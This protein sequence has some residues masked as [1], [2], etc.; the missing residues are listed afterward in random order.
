MSAASDMD[1]M[2]EYADRDSETAFA[3]LVH[4]H[5]NLVYSVALRSTGNSHDAQD[6]T[7]AVFVI[8]AKKATSLRQRTYLTGWLYE[9]TRFTSRQLLRTRSRQQAR[10][11]EAYMQST[12][13]DSET[14]SLWRQLAPL[15]DDAMSRLSEKDRALVA[16]RFFEN[17]SVAE[18]AAVLGIQEWAARKRVERAMQKLRGYFYKHGVAS[19]TATLAVAISVNSVQAAPT[20]LA[21]TAAAAAIAKGAAASTSTLTLAKGALNV[22]A[23]TKAKTAIVAGVG[24]LLAI[25]IGTTATV[26]VARHQ[27]S[28]QTQTSFPRS[29]WANAGYADPASALETIFWAQTQGDGKTYLASMTPELQQRL[30][31]QF[32]GDLAKQGLSLEDFLAQKSKDHIRPV[33]GFYIWGQQNVSGQLLLRVWIP[34]ARKNATFK[35]RKTE[36]E[37]KLDEEFLPDY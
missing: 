9:T 23:W 11:Q 24:I 37:W 14:D 35:M 7:Q 15:L 25:G 26:S 22:M 3:E 2:R 4:R 21:Q 32:A 33:T 16:L 27:H 8:L 1:L 10:E 20:A 34:G 12:L 29:S 13:N 36:N 6:I 17:K 19:T 18:T 5:V 28:I 30:Q 31:Q